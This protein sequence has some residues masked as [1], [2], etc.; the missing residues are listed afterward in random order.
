VGLCYNAKCALAL[1][2]GSAL[3][4]AASAADL[5]PAPML[6]APVAARSWTGLYGGLNVGYGFGAGGRDDGARPVT[7]TTLPPPSSPSTP[8]LTALA[9]RRGIRPPIPAA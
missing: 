5:G 2:C 4:S 1:L 3:I 8:K 7:P 6:S 9:D